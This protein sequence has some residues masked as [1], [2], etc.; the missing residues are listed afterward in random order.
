MGTDFYEIKYLN[1][2]GTQSARSYT[3]FSRKDLSLGQKVVAPTFKNERQV[4][5]VFAVN[6][7]EPTFK[8]REITEIVPE[9]ED[10]A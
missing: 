7:P 3:Y 4:G 10:D 6:V 5:V 1:P 2:D 8:C 9:G